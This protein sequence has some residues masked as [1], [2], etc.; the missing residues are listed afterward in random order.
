MTR[1][2][3]FLTFFILVFLLIS[4]ESSSIAGRIVVNAVGDIMLAGKGTVTYRREGYGYPFAA[5]SSELKKGDITIGNLEA[6]LTRRGTEFSGKKYRFRADPASAGPLKIAGFTV[7]TLANNHI[8]DYGAVGLKD[9]VTNLDK[10]GIFHTGAGEYLDIARK[11]ALLVVRNEKVAIFSYS[12]TF[13]V[14]F[15]ARHRH[16]GT[17]PGLGLN[18]KNDIAAAKSK[19][20]YVIVTFHWGTENAQMP[21]PYQIAAAH[22]AI[23]AGADIVIGHHPHVLQGIERYGNGI[24]FYSMGNFAFGCVNDGPGISAIARITLD[25]G[26]KEAEILPL[27][28]RNCEIHFQPR[29]LGGRNGMEVINH[30]NTLS[31]PFGTRI[32]TEGSH[33]FLSDDNQG[34]HFDQH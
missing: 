14:E 7:L 4:N 1:L 8:M 34:K 20:N 12:L 13:P 18:F 3:Y 26:R 25:N 29:I 17:S 33:Y 32:R 9:T 19:Y 27:N 22:A 31:K 28:I 30:L 23:D 16:A 11:P 5:V 24:I 10:A 21:S 15:Y 6:P 2:N